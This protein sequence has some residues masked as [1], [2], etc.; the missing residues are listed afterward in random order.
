MFRNNCD[1][2]QD[3]NAKGEG[4][5]TT[6]LHDTLTADGT[7]SVAVTSYAN[8]CLDGCETDGNCKKNN[9]MITEFG[10]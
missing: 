2:P 8:V 5:R 6:R 10:Q 3:F 4:T 7:K 1:P 9:R